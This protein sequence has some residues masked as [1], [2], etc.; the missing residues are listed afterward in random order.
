MA[1]RRWC[2][3]K[4]G[5][6]H[7]TM[8]GTLSNSERELMAARVRVQELEQEVAELRSALTKMFGKLA[9]VG[10]K[11]RQGLV[12][13]GAI[14]LANG[15]RVCLRHIETYGP[16]GDMGVTITMRSG[17]VVHWPQRDHG[18]SRVD[19]LSFLDLLFSTPKELLPLPARPKPATP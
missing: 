14:A 12:L 7:K 19:I 6:Q 4:D 11:D 3:M 2:C 17:A 10:A 1:W 13:T 8:N 15:T 16:G 9:G 18:E 5:N